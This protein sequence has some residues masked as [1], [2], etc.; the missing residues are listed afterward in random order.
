MLFRSTAVAVA[1]AAGQIRLRSNET[2]VSF[3]RL[4]PADVDALIAAGDWRGK[5][6]GYAL[7]GAAEAW[8]RWLSGSWSGVVGLPLAD[9]RALLIASGWRGAGT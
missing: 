1:D 6:G 4:T 7:Q 3:L 8:V 9:T 2:I 5:A